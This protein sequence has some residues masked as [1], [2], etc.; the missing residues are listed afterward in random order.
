MKLTRRKTIRLGLLGGI[1]IGLSQLIPNLSALRY[2]SGILRGRWL[3][4]AGGTTP[5]AVVRCPTYADAK[6]AVRQAWDLAGGPSIAGKRVVLKPNLVDHL[7][8]RPVHTAP[9]VVEAAIEYLADKGASDV[10]VADGPCFS[11]DAD[12]LLARSGLGKALERRGV[13][14]VDLNYDDLD[15]VPL[16]G[17]YGPLKRLLLPRTITRADLVI[18]VPKLKVH[19]WSG[20]SLSMKNL[21]GVVPGA[22]YGWPKNSLHYNGIEPSILTLYETI[23]PQLALVD[24]VVGLEDDGPIYGTPR[25]TGVVVVGSDP[26]AVDATA[27]RIMGIDPRR[28]AHLSFAGAL[29]LG[30]VSADQIAVVG[31]K[32]AD[33]AQVYAPPPMGLLNEEG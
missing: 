19:H 29:G 14:F 24:G 33:V 21:F 26:V 18:S 12:E 23:R 3:R 16:K 22:K 25:H 5:V 20:V 1:G 4:L 6:L 10:V 17:N 11:R 28:V 32:L 30:R 2:S 9:E 15:D 8:D 31:T 27:T 7:A 13:R